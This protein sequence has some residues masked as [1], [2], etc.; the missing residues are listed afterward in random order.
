MDLDELRNSIRECDRNIISL[1]KQ[2]QMISQS[3][4]ESKIG[5]GLEIID[6]IQRNKVID[7]AVSLAEE[8][9]LDK[10]AV[11]LIFNQ[12][13]TMS[14]DVQRHWIESGNINKQ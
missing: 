1:I 5:L 10:D 2:R 14:E 13:I 9:S 4:A 8:Y 3:I 12:L 7:H 6:E 11:R